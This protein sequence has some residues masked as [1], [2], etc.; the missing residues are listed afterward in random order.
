MNKNKMGIYKSVLVGAIL[1][2]SLTA[3]GAGG[4]FDKMN[5][6]FQDAPIGQRINQKVDII[7]MPDGYGNIATTCYKGMRYSTST[8]GGGQSEAR[9]ISVTV[10]PTC[11]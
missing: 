4:T 2:L 1:G 8:V 9:A 3:C 7:E 5:E 10:D 6:P 11:K